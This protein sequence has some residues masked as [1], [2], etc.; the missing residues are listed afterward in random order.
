MEV[1]VVI[2]FV[3]HVLHGHS[4][5]LIHLVLEPILMLLSKNAMAVS[6]LRE[7][8]RL[9]RFKEC[10]C[11]VLDH[12]DGEIQL[13]GCLGIGLGVQG[14]PVDDKVMYSLVNSFVFTDSRHDGGGRNTMCGER[15]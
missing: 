2:E 9:V 8:R 4:W 7:H 14:T 10:I 6:T 15:W 1:E 13:S 3:G 5:I 11:N 12:G